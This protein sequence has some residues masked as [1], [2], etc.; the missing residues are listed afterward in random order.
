[1]N[2]REFLSDGKTRESAGRA[3][4][5][6]GAV[7][8]GLTARGYRAVILARDLRPGEFAL[9]EIEGGR[10]LRLEW[11]PAIGEPEAA[12]CTQEEAFP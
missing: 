4:Q 1:M 3:M 7:V 9:Y 10:G 11:E 5:A 2:V 8:N 6:A 12:R